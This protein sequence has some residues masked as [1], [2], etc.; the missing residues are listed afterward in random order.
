MKAVLSTRM[1]MVASASI[2]LI[3]IGVAETSGISFPSISSYVQAEAVSAARDPDTGVI[4]LESEPVQCT[5][6]CQ[7]QADERITLCVQ[8][9]P[10][11][12]MRSVGIT[13]VTSCHKDTQQIYG[14]CLANCGLPSTV[15]HGRP[16][17]KPQLPRRQGP[18]VIAA[19]PTK[20]VA[21]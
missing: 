2:V 1:T 15:P 9:A 10:E 17:A 19:E 18:H 5:N 16:F 8:S 14:V 7:Q 12:E 4:R 21:P 6:T 13:S 3:G 11:A 20:A